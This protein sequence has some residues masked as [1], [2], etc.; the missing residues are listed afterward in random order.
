[1]YTVFQVISNF[2]VGTLL[3]FGYSIP[4]LLKRTSSFGTFFC[5]TFFCRVV[6]R[7]KNA[8][9]ELWEFL[10]MLKKGQGSRFLRYFSSRL[11]LKYL[12]L[13][14]VSIMNYFV[15]NFFFVLFFETC[16]L[17]RFGIYYLWFINI[18]C[19]ILFERVLSI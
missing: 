4:H 3:S 12:N 1:M 9:D 16:N 5:Q 13:V 10:E 14:T 8:L 19:S 17:E 11:I 15:N 6:A 18:C 2:F 7:S